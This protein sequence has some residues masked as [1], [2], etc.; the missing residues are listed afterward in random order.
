MQSLAGGVGERA[1]RGQVRRGHQVQAVAAGEALAG[2]D[3]ARDP[4]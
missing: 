4:I 3:L 1:K 2:G